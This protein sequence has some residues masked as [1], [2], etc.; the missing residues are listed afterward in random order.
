[1]EKSML[2]MHRLEALICDQCGNHS[3]IWTKKLHAT[4]YRTEE[5]SAPA[6]SLELAP[7]SLL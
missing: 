6:M 3:V 1:M 7:F 2:I 4:I 5:K